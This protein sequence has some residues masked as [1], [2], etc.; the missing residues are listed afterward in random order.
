MANEKK[1]HPNNQGSDHSG[2]RSG[3]HGA[4]TVGHAADCG[5]VLLTHAELPAFC[6]NPKMPLWNHHPKV[7]LD[8]HHATEARCPYC[9]TTYKLSA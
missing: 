9:G 4:H 3:D 5:V 1:A 2:N 8:L 7:F 6:P